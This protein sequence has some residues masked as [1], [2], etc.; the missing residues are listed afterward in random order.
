[1][2]NVIYLT[3]ISLALVSFTGCNEQETVKS[4][5]SSMEK[6]Q[7]G[8]CGDAKEAASKAVETAETT[9]ED[10]KAAA[11]Q[12]AEEMTAKQGEAKE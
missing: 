6:C 8:K 7:S 10:A 5:A 1:M 4:E 11:S 12:A 3:M 2:K 9:K